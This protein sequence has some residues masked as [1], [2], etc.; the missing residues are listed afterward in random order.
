[1]MIQ[2][3]PAGNRTGLDLTLESIPECK[4]V[5]N[6]ALDSSSSF[7]SYPSYQQ[8]LASWTDFEQEVRETFKALPWDQCDTPITFQPDVNNLPEN[9]L[10]LEQ[11]LYGDDK[12]NELERYVQ[13]VLHVM[14]AVARGMGIGTRFGYWK[15]V[16]PRESEQ[17]EETPDYAILDSD[18]RARCVGLGRT[19]KDYGFFEAYSLFR[20]G[21]QGPLR[22]FIGGFEFH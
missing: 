1:M 7:K 17:V 12:S 6:Q 20:S 2:T 10:F 3:H 9:H 16:A 18:R 14:S 4:A 5:G 11:F 13:H 15:A 19:P 21:N 22:K 8:S